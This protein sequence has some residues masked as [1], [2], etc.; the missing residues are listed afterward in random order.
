MARVHHAGSLLALAI[1][2]GFLA[3]GR[4]AAQESNAKANPC[5]GSANDEEVRTCRLEQLDR[6]EA[7]LAAI[8]A[9]LNANYEDDSPRA[10]ALKAA[11][12][13]WLRFRDA[14]CKLMTIDSVSGTMFDVYWNVCLIEQNVRRIA[15][16]QW[17]VDNP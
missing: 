11:H 3:A 4:P 2:A 7:D 1:I 5:A 9:L 6:S 8:V 16:M 17:L 10:D 13:A 12:E 15:Q 14:E